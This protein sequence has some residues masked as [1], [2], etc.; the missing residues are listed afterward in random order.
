MLFASVISKISVKNRLIM[1]IAVAGLVI[2]FVGI[3]GLYA[4]SQ[5]N[6][7]LQAVYEEQM[8]PAAD[9]N[10]L[11]DLLHEV[12]T[13]ILLALQHDTQLPASALHDHP[14]SL[15]LDRAENYLQDINRLRGQLLERQRNGE[16]AQLAT[17]FLQ[18]LDSYI[19]RGV[20]PAL[21]E[22]RNNNFAPVYMLVTNQL[23]TR[24]FVLVKDPAAA[25]LKLNLEQAASYYQQQRQRAQSD[26]LLLTALMLGGLTLI[27][28]LAFVTIRTIAVGVARTRKMTERLAHGDLTVQMKAEGSDEFSQI[29]Q[30]FNNMAGR[31]KE[32]LTQIISAAEQLASGALQAQAVT[33]RSSEAILEQLQETEQVATAMNEMSATVQEVA[34]NATQTA[35]ATDNAEEQT[36]KGAH[37]V[38]ATRSVIS[39]VAHETGEVCTVILQLEKDSQSIGSI[40]DVIREIADQTNLLALNAAIEAARAGDQGRGFAVVADEVRSLAKRTQQSTQDIQE[41]IGRLQERALSAAQAMQAGQQ[42]TTLAVDQANEANKA[43]QAIAD[44]MTTINNMTV[45]IAS[46]AEE[47]SSVTEEMNRS[48]SRI[49]EV[50]NETAQGAQENNLTAQ[51]LVQLAEKL[52]QITSQFRL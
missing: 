46:A 19:S 6:R 16:E 9:V 50:A 17:Q 35:Q 45:Q 44:A 26:R 52:K 31:F 18:Q 12:R 29:G 38:A 8:M 23:S 48:I 22:L 39:E 51:N 42:R 30:A 1:L 13:E 32:L 34:G 7:I 3:K 40:L 15:H 27:L 20:N 4:Q 14:T 28:V 11:L 33:Q 25:Y 21:R 24:Q 41:L 5:S 47:Q 10:Q 43:L 36:R 49:N 2:L 37:V